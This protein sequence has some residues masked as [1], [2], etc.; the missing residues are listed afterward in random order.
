MI[1]SKD[2]NKLSVLG[3]LNSGWLKLL[4]LTL[5]HNVIN[6]PLYLLM[7]VGDFYQ[8]FPYFYTVAFQVHNGDEEGVRL[9]GKAV[10]TMFRI[11][12]NYTLLNSSLLAIAIIAFIFFG[13]FVILVAVLIYMG[14]IKESYGHMLKLNQRYGWI[15]KLLSLFLKLLSTNGIN[16]LT[17]L[18]ILPL[19]CERINGKLVFSS[20]HSTQCWT[21]FHIIV[22]VTT[23]LVLL[24]LKGLTI[25]LEIVMCETNPRSTIPWANTK[26]S[27]GLVVKRIANIALISLYLVGKRDNIYHYFF[28]SQ[29]LC[30][31]FIVYWIFISPPFFNKWVSWFTLFEHSAFFFMYFWG[32]MIRL[33]NRVLDYPDMIIL[34]VIFVFFPVLV[35]LIKQSYDKYLLSNQSIELEEE[36]EKEHY[37]YSLFKL[38]DQYA[39]SN[40]SAIIFLNGIYINHQLHCKNADCSCMENPLNN[41][42]QAMAE[43][44]GKDYENR[45]ILKL[46]GAEEVEKQRLKKWES[47]SS[48]FQALDTQIKGYENEANSPRDKNMAEDFGTSN[49]QLLLNLTHSLIDQEIKENLR[50]SSLRLLSSYYAK[51]YVGNIF[52][53]IYDL[54]Y[55]EEKLKPSMREQFLVFKAKKDINEEIAS[56]SQKKAGENITNV[57]SLILFEE[58]YKSFRNYVELGSNYANRFWELMKNKDIDVNGLYDIGSK[59]GGIYTEM[60]NNYSLAIAIFPNNLNLVKEF[61]DFE[62]HVM[63]NEGLANEFEAEVKR[64]MQEQNENSSEAERNDIQ[65]MRS[66][67]HLCICLISGNPSNLGDILS[68]N[69]EALYNLGFR[70]KELNGQSSAV[71]CPPFIGSKHN[72]MIE[73][74]IQAGTTNFLG[75]LKVIPACNNKGFIVL[76]EIIIKMLPCI[77]QGLCFVSLIKKFD[78]YSMWFPNLNLNCTAEDFAMIIANPAGKILG[79]TETCMTRLGIPISLYKSKPL[80]DEALTMQALIRELSQEKIIEELKSKGRRIEIDTKPFLYSINRENL[81]EREAKCL[82]ENAGKCSVFMR[83]ATENF[84]QGLELHYYRM[85]ILKR[86]VNECLSTELPLPTKEN[87]SNDEDEKN[88]PLDILDDPD[89]DTR[90][91]LLQDRGYN[92]IKQNLNTKAT[93]LQV[94]TM[95]KWVHLLIILA[96]GLVTAQFVLLIIERRKFKLYTEIIMNGNTRMM[97]TGLLN[98]HVYANKRM[99]KNGK[100]DMLEGSINLYNYLSEYGFRSIRILNSAEKWINIL[101]FKSSGGLKRLEKSTTINLYSIGSFGDLSNLTH[102][103]NTGIIKYTSKVSDILSNTIT[104]LGEHFKGVRNNRLLSSYFFVAYNGLSSL[105]DTI[106][107]TVNQYTETMKEKMNAYLKYYIIITVI[108]G[109]AVMIFFKG[110]VPKLVG[111]QSEKIHILLLYTQMNRNEVNAQIERCVEYQKRTG[112]FDINEERQASSQEDFIPEEKQDVEDLDKEVGFHSSKKEVKKVNDVISDDDRSESNI[113]EN[114]KTIYSTLDTEKLNSKLIT[115]KF[116]LIVSS[117]FVASLFCSHSL[118]NTIYAWSQ[119]NEVEDMLDMINGV[120]QMMRF[121]LYIALNA[122]VPQ[123]EDINTLIQFENKER[124]TYYLRN[125]MIANAFT[126]K[127]KTSSHRFMESITASYKRLDGSGL[128]NEVVAL[129]KVIRD[130]F[131]DEN[132]DFTLQRS[133]TSEICSTYKSGLLN[134]GITQVLYHIYQTFNRMHSSNNYIID[135]EAISCLYLNQ[136]F[137]APTIKG[138]LIMLNDTIVHSLK[139]YLNFLIAFYVCYVVLVTIA[140]FVFWSCFFSSMRREIIRSRGML[141]LM[142]MELIKRLKVM[143]SPNKDSAI[144]NSLTYFKQFCR[145]S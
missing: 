39:T 61:G 87:Q 133:L 125:F 82:E 127:L 126:H 35:I 19:N 62:R 116:W 68:I 117:L 40:F 24:I 7:I 64:I 86:I 4:T 108:I 25:Y 97:Y 89:I 131:S 34:S 111:L 109:I 42:L 141:K 2:K 52:K 18:F 60:N 130:Y 77:D 142:P 90:R 92:E 41:S 63:N 129:H 119:Q 17:V 10:D 95:N 59:L 47:F 96:L 102:T 3:K 71:L 69:D 46:K 70:P 80:S 12:F 30:Q 112:Y 113:D 53:A 132:Y 44:M 83:L 49:Y 76:C 48:L 20:N 22:V 115:K 23:L 107:N 54:F 138:L 144:S 28:T 51:E 14:S 121:P 38:L 93:K 106:Y 33:V 15:F 101:Q 105:P 65:L 43:K 136:V 94:T 73:R 9:Y 45:D 99:A 103:L 29:L 5:E 140:H 88:E 123:D 11:T 122:I 67:K 56:F 100:A 128:C 75:R 137:V 72:A 13:L 134:R 145:K 120:T 74:L 58:N 16:M 98:S 36:G 31:G 135:D 79:I 26:I 84:S 8:L 143:K 104:E 78:N 124:L 27:K 6:L 91:E 55:I 110:G 21:V 50:S 85:I 37:F 66:A 114:E 139:R 32:Y 118:T 57:E 1:E 81:P